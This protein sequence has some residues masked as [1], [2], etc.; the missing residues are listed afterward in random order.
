MLR[1]VYEFPAEWKSPPLVY[2]LLWN[3]R[4]L[5]AEGKQPLETVDLKGW[6]LEP[7]TN[8]KFVL[9]TVAD[10][11]LERNA[12]PLSSGDHSVV[13]KLRGESTVK[14]LRHSSVYDD[15]MLPEST[16]RREYASK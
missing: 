10:G 2:T 11:K 3:W 6:I 15:I 16:E 8:P 7:V 14:S 4:Q 13:L 1:Q 9:I 5:L 12:E